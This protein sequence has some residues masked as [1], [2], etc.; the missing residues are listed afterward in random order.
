MANAVS[1]SAKT[2]KVVAINTI[3]YGKPVLDDDGKPVIVERMHGNVRRK[4]QLAENVH[5]QAGQSFEADAELLKEL[6]AKKL[7]RAPDP[8]LDDDGDDV[9]DI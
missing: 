5:V 4:V 6:K 3:T 1:P 9:D 7:V 2:V 8:V